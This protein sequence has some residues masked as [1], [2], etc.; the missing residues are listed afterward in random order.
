MN[1]DE[2]FNAILEKEGGYVNHPDDKGGPTNWGI[3][4][5]TARAHGYD[6]D[7]QKLTRQQALDI[8][9]ADYWIAPRF[10]HVAEISTAIAEKLC[11][12]GV[13]MG[14]VLPGKWLQR[15]LNAFNHRGVLYPDLITDGV[16]GPRLLRAL[17]C[18]QGQYYLEL[19]EKS[20]ANKSFIYGWLRARI[21]M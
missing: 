21:A 16:I 11:D 13:N 14:P 3:T 2:I 12:A 18:S 20:E 1:K 6:G 17:N 8:L 15:W 4:Q 9:N 19:A 7:M 5:V 10:D